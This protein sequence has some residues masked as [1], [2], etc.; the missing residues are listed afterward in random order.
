MTCIAAIATN[1][2]VYMAGERSL[3]DKEVIVSLRRPKITM[4]NGYL[5]AYAGSIGVGQLLQFIELPS[6]GK[7]SAKSIRT[8][9]IKN[10]KD[11]IENYGPVMSEDNHSELLIAHRSS[12]YEISTQDWSVSD[13]AC[14]SIGSGSGFALGSL[15]TTSHYSSPEKRL[16][17]AL[18]AA[19]ALSPTCL[20]PIDILHT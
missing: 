8:A 20:G 2:A 7:D 15:Y 16:R 13:V 5:I 11:A 14:T 12:L 6:P 19:I 18:E 1:D 3:S 9:V 17:I 4:N 10:F